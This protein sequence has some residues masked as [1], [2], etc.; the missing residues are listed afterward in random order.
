MNKV[1][2]ITGSEYSGWDTVAHF[3]NDAPNE[4]ILFDNPVVTF[5]K[6]LSSEATHN[7]A[8][9]SEAKKC[10][11]QLISDESLGWAD[12]STVNFLPYWASISQACQFVLVYSS[13]ERAFASAI[14]THDDDR[15]H[16]NGAMANW[17]RSVRT[18]L[19]FFQKNRSRCLLVNVSAVSEQSEVLIKACSK[20]LG[21]NISNTA[22]TESNSNSTQLYTVEILVHII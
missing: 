15:S 6:G 12:N 22:Q 17:E 19:D 18:T 11:T 9:I 8:T 13:P 14:N 20:L 4:Q 1:L 10:L 3:L 7:K 5:N 2:V 21:Q 16:V